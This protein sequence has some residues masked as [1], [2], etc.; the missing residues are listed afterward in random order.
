MPLV[1]SDSSG[2]ITL[3][4]VCNAIIYAADHG[5][6]I[7]NMS[8]AFYG[9]V[10]TLQSAVNYAW[11]KGLII[12]ASAGNYS[13]S[14]PYYPAAFSNVLGVSALSPSGSPSSFS[15]YGNWIKLAAPG[16]QVYTTMIGGSYGYGSGTSVSSPIVAGAAALVFSLNPS[17]TNAQVFQLLTANA[18]D[19]GGNGFDNSYGWGRVNLQRTLQVAANTSGLAVD[20][21]SP[22]NGT[23]LQPGT[24][25]VQVNARASAGVSKVELYVDGA[26]QGSSTTSPFTIPWYTG[27]NSA[28]HSLIAKVFDKNNKSASSPTETVTVTAITTDTTPPL[29][30]LTSVGIDNR[31]LTATVS[32]SDS[33]SG[34]AKVDL[35]V[36][37]VLKA[38]DTSSP[39]G[40][41]VNARSWSKGTHSVQAKAYDR[42][43]NSAT[44]TPMS[45]TK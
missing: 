9:T 2:Q 18:D 14:T 29:V 36:D 22:P 4:N 40:F 26:L 6:N 8:M 31:F 23:T 42:V 44:S 27:S 43:G 24:V 3:A 7:I 25:N 1:V 13:T 35:Y 20:I 45:V 19:L 30:S 34:I 32:A 11:N 41:K 37:G 16:E 38:T 10:D 33:Q 5:A 28:Q 17:L 39:W 12:V 21:V 15:N